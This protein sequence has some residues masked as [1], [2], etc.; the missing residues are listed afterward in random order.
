MRRWY[1]AAI[2]VF[3][4]LLI[5]QLSK[6]WI[7]TNMALGDTMFDVGFF[8]LH[9][10]E[11]NG[12]AFGTEFG[13]DNGKLFLSLF[14]IV[15][16][17]VIGYYLV[18]F[19]KKKYH[20]GLIL[21]MSLVFTGALGNIIDSIFYGLIFDKTCWCPP[22]DKT[23]CVFQPENAYCID[24][25]TSEMVPMGNGYADI[26]YGRVVDMMQF[27]MDWPSW[28]PWVGGDPVFPFIFNVADVAISVG[29]IAI[30]I[31]SNKF[32]PESELG[33]WNFLNW[34]KKKETK[35]ELNESDETTS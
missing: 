11:N 23:G 7:K 18:R 26:F 19:I 31:W 27:T 16:I 15:A 14:R 32:F 34:F 8:Q 10:I 29:V 28:M 5:D 6:I 4:V 22:G 25:S 12:M 30:I 3:G 13:G 35:T 2:T 20:K 24:G 9:F 21:S 17:G 1:L 33:S